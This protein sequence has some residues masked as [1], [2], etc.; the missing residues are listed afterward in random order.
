MGYE[1]KFP[2]MRRAEGPH[3][4]LKVGDLVTWI[5]TKTLTPCPSC[6]TPVSW[7]IGDRWCLQCVE[8][9]PVQREPS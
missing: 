5:S 1:V 7:G 8:W 2:P 6:K 9:R 3:P 4:D